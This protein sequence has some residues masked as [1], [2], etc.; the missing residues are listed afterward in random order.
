R[1]SPLDMALVAGAV[2]SGTWRAPLLVTKPPVQRP[3]RPR[4]SSAVARQL[5]DL[6]RSTVK[7]GAAQAADVPGGEV[8]G[9]VGAAPLPGQR[10][11]WAIWFVGFRGK[12]AFAAVVFARSASFSPAVQIAGQFA[13]GLPSG[14]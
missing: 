2:E 13:G 12:V 1:V 10:G 9:Q 7:S 8:F 14:S 3:T 11:L 4:L 6:M 5:R